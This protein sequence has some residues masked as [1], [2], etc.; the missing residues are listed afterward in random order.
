MHLYPPRAPLPDRGRARRH[1][2]VGLLDRGRRADHLGRRR[3]DRAA[4]HARAEAGSPRASRRA[5][6]AVIMKLGRNLAKVRARWPRR[7]RSTAP[8]TSSAAPWRAS[9][10]MPLATS[11][12]R[13]ALLLASSWCPARDGGRDAARCTIVGLGPGRGAGWTPRRRARPLGRGDRPRRLRPLCRPRRR[14]ARPAPPRLR[15]PR[16]AGARPPRAR[17]GRRRADASRS[18]RAA[19]PGV[20]AMA[21]AVFEAIEAG[22]PAWRRAGRRACCPASPPCW[23]PPRAAGAPLGPRLLRHLPVGQPQA[24]GGR[25]SAACGGAARRLRDR[26]LQPG[27]RGPARAAPRGLR[28]AAAAAGRPDAGGLRPRRR[29]AGRGHAPSCHAGRGRRRHGRHAHAGL[30]GS[31]TTR[32][33]RARRRRA[34]GLHAALGAG[35]MTRWPA[36]QSKPAPAPRRRSA[37]CPRAARAARTMTTGRPSARAA[38][39][40]A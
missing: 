23:P 28:A 33:H 19:I 40:L 18:C 6:A 8:S 31:S 24:L 21:A 16:R 34:L 15:Q 22:D 30:I 11:R 3:A 29:P 9:V 20:F 4:R 1:R 7:A 10:V 26:A 27:L 17:A 5:D 2:H 14:R 32:L 37:R 25:S 38:A 13:G 39:S 12:R 35:C 36:T